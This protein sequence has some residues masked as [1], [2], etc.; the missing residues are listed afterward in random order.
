MQL[1]PVAPCCSRSSDNRSGTRVVFPL[2]DLPLVPS[3]SLLA[4]FFTLALFRRNAGTRLLLLG[5]QVPRNVGCRSTSQEGQ[6]GNG[7]S[8]LLGSLLP[9]CGDGHVTFL[10][11][12]PEESMTPMWSYPCLL[13]IWAGGRGSCLGPFPPCPPKLYIF[14]FFL[15]KICSYCGCLG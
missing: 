13:T 15:F 7:I 6:E 10:I 5:G 4:T 2:R 9:H 12:G 3:E 11:L 14:L 1:P 8:A